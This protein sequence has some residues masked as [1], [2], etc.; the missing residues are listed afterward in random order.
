MREKY[1]SLHPAAGVM[2]VPQAKCTTK[3]LINH[4][5]GNVVYL[6]STFHYLTSFNGNIIQRSVAKK[7]DFGIPY[8]GYQGNYMV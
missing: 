5:N 6:Q 3:K 8:K 7:C 4:Q 1:H 2:L